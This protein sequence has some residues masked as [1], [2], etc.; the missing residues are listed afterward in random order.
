MIRILFTLLISFPCLAQVQSWTIDQC[1]DTA[2]ANNLTI[3]KME[4]AQKVALSNYQTSKLNLL[5]SIDAN[6]SHGYNWGQ[7][8]D[9]FTNQFATN[10]VQYDNFFLSSSVTLFQGLQ[11]YYKIQQANMS[12]KQ[13]LLDI[14]IAKRNIRIDVSAAFSQVLLNQSIVVIYE[15]NLK[16]GKTQLKRINSLMEHNQA[17]SMNLTEIKTQIAK[18]EYL[19]LKATN[20]LKLTK[21]VLQ[22]IMNVTVSDRF[23]IQNDLSNSVQLSSLSDSTIN[24]LPEIIKIDFGIENQSYLIKSSKG[25]YYPSLFLRG[26]LGSGYSENNKVINSNG[27]F[28]PKAFDDQINDN[29]YQSVSL[30]LSIPIFNKGATRNQIK[31]SELQLQSLELEKQEQKIALK[32]QLE[33]LFI[34]IENLNNQTQSLEVSQNLAQM[35]MENMQIRYENGDANFYQLTEA[36]N[37]FLQVQSELVQV[38]YQM[39]FKQMILGYYFE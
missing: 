24:K 27:L 28:I 34:E 3:Q 17:T 6:V 19:L 5:P 35:N 2:L 21:V 13:S 14:E 8:I 11:N 1:I 23:S 37:G 25:R 32:Q 4:I 38:K 29:F 30:T 16:Q 33:Q 18:D 26:S 7:T 9:L 22:N 12:T 20:D 39:M 15:Q 10:R 36:K 31:L